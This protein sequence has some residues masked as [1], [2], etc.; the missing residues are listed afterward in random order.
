MLSIELG[1]ARPIPSPVALCLYRVV[2]ESLNNIAKYAGTDCARVTLAEREMEYQLTIEDEGN[3]FDPAKA[4]QKQ[5]IGLS[6]MEERVLLL[7]GRMTVQSQPRVGTR[8]QAFI[9]VNEHEDHAANNAFFS[10]GSTPIR[11]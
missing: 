10:Q 1:Q 9:P 5:G 7:N 3:G 4:R 2:Q 6:S 8:V 11:V